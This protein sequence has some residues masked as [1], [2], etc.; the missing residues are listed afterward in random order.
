MSTKMTNN[1]LA[2]KLIPPNNH[3]NPYATAHRGLNRY[4]AYA[5]FRSLEELSRYY[6]S[7]AFLPV[8]IKVVPMLDNRTLTK[9][10]TFAS[11]MALTDT[12][13]E[14]KVRDEWPK[15]LVAAEKQLHPRRSAV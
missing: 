6:L 12:H 4:I 14:G 10:P 7:P 11:M 13:L 9:F 15:D 2:A 3:T 1:V 5:G 8:W